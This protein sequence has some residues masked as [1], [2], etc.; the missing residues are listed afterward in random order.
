MVTS[1]GLEAGYRPHMAPQIGENI[2][3]SV[4]MPCLNEAET[5]EV[6]I[7]KAREALSQA[8]IS[9]EILI[10]DNGSTDDSVEISERMG[11]MVVHVT[12]KGYGNALMGGIAAARGKYRDGRRGQQLPTSDIFHDSWS[13]CDKELMW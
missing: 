2:E 9:G 8:N 4:V 6:C 3:V 7:A 10:A 11:A 12:A 13:S 1:S 5:V